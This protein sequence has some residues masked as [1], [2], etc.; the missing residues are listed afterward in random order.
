MDN[1]DILKFVVVDLFSGAGGVTT[2]IEQAEVNGIKI[3][4]VCC[5]INHDDLAIESHWRNHPHVKHFVE[6]IRTFNVK[7]LPKINLLDPN[8]RKFLWA[9]LEC[10]NHSNAKGGLSRDADSRALAEHMPIYLI[11]W[12]PD[13]FGVENVRE[14]KEWGP[15]IQKVD[16]KN[17][18]MLDKHNK[19]MMIPD[20]TKK[21][22]YF[23]KWL[24][25]ICN[26]GYHYEIKI[27]NAADFGAHTSRKRLF[28]L[29]AKEGLPICWPKPTHDKSG[30]SGL[31]KR[32]PVKECLDFTD[33]GE[34]IFGRKINLC[35]NTYK[36]IY[37]GLVKYIA[38]GDEAFLE[39]Y[40]GW[41]KDNRIISMDEPANTITTMNRFGLI[42]PEFIQQRNSGDP[43]S[44]ICS[45]EDPARTLTA[46]GGNLEI[47]QTEAF[48]QKYMGNNQ[49]TK[50]NQGKSI[51]EPSSVITTQVRMS[52]VQT[53]FLTKYHGHGENLLSVEE[54]SSTLSTKDR[55]G[56]VTAEHFIDMQHG[57]GKQNESVN[58]P[59]GAILPVVKKNLVTVERFIDQQF[60]ESEPKSIEEP[61]NTLTANPKYN[62]VTASF[63]SNP[64]YE[65]KGGNVDDPCFTLIGKMD[66]R[67]PSLVQA[68]IMDTQYDNIGTSIEDPA[69]TLL[70]S[71][72]YPYLIQTESGHYAVK[73]EES[74]TEYMQKIKLFMAVYGIIAIYMRMLRIPELK[75]I[76]GFSENYILEG[77]QADQKK[78][79]GNAVP[80]A[81]IKA[82]FEALSTVDITDSKVRVAV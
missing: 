76:T 52:L 60:G 24:K 5:A 70:S 34:N 9:S 30:A 35:E 37:A 55:L 81:V 72:R 69:P 8:L 25:D 68:Y 53:E 82:M 80:P 71:R 49:H 47:V 66:K 61:C 32:K 3:A 31:P 18:P 57:S 26:L 20:K 50:I 36:R 2:G 73:V 62:L 74:D 43:K 11:E 65:S 21:G 40:N 19:P 45:I 42:Q 78:F 10:T 17:K 75:R 23:N 33:K 29:F 13:Y 6:D 48:I 67:P 1:S 12:N 58:E 22:I 46:T 59:I 64:Q 77:T 51:D 56:L 15:L 79:I 28:I 4:T 44:K 7:K 63:L 38:H 54:P 14:F 41:G 39:Q 27:L 16:V